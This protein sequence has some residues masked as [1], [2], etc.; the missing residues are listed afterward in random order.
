MNQFTLIS[1]LFNYL[2]FQLITNNL[3]LNQLITN[4]ESVNYLN[5]NQLI[6]NFQLIIKQLTL[7]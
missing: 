3:N 5:L 4:L 2:M 7:N 1:S 6:T